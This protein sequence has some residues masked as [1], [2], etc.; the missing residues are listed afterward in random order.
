MKKLLGEKDA[1]FDMTHV[2]EEE[3]DSK[4]VKRTQVYVENPRKRDEK[5]QFEQELNVL[6]M[7]KFVLCREKGSLLYN[8]GVL[9]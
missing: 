7:F 2:R 3:S 5:P 6:V 1:S 4:S 9:P 8:K